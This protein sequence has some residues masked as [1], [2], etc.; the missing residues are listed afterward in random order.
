[1]NNLEYSNPDGSVRVAVPRIIQLHPESTEQQ[2]VVSL[3][4]E[5]AGVKSME[6]SLVSP[7]PINWASTPVP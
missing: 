5:I 7:G 2:P 4:W 6:T 1:M 3:A